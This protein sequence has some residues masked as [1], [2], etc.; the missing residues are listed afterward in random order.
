MPQP[1]A[2]KVLLDRAHANPKIEIR[3][4]TKIEKIV[5]EDHVTAIELESCNTGA[6]SRL[7]VEGILVRI[8]L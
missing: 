2:S 8:G 5:G 6:K 4:A 3:C 1:K 7:E